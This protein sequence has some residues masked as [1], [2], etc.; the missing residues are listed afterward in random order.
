MKIEVNS[1]FYLS[2]VE[3]G[4]LLA[5][6]HSSQSTEELNIE[7]PRFISSSKRADRM[8]NTFLD[9]SIKDRREACISVSYITERSS[10]PDVRGLSFLQESK[11]VKFKNMPALEGED[12]LREAL[13]LVKTR[14]RYDADQS[15][16]SASASIEKGYGVCVNFAH[17]FIGVMR[18]NGIP[19]RVAVGVPYGNHEAAHAWCQIKYEG[20]WIEVDP[21]A[22]I[23]GDILPYALWGI[24][25]D[26]SDVRSKVIGINPKIK[27]IHHVRLLK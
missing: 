27:E 22:G 19:A 12:K 6:P 15:V 16:K 23:F 18:R 11:Y 26:E 13:V 9:F 20:K 21:T 17:V 14:M 5:L 7:H 2:G 4:K 8:G 1:T 10:V 24:G 25:E 3:R